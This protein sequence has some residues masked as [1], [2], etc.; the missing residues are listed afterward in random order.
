MKKEIKI[1]VEND[2]DQ[3]EFYM[4]ANALDMYSALVNVRA[5]I[6]QR[7]KYENCKK[8]EYEFLESL[9]E[10]SYVESVGIV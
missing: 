9:M 5:A 2:D 6:R 3:D 1:T 10:H 7:M 8:K 4:V